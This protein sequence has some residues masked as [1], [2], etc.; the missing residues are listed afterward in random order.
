VRRRQSQTTTP[1]G[2][3]LNGTITVSWAR[4]PAPAS[5]DVLALYPAGAPAG[6]PPLAQRRT[7]GADT[8]STPFVVPGNLAAGTY[9]MR[10]LHVD[11]T[12]VGLSNPINLATCSGVC[13]TTDGA[14]VSWTGIASPTSTDFF[15]LYAVGAP[16]S[17][18]VP[19]SPRYVDC[20]ASAGTQ[21][22]PSGSCPLYWDGPLAPGSYEVRLFGSNNLDNDLG[23]SNAFV[24]GGANQTSPAVPPRADYRFQT[25]RASSVSGAPDVADVGSGGATTFGTEVVDGTSRAVLTFP[26]HTGLAV[27]TS[28]ILSAGTYS[29]V[30]LFRLQGIAGFNRLVDFKSGT[31]DHGLYVD[32]GKLSFYPV[33]ASTGSPLGANRYVQLVLTR[34]GT[35]KQVVGYVDGVQWLSFVDSADDG[36]IS[37]ANSLRFFKDDGAEDPS[38]AVARIRLFDYVLTPSVAVALDRLPPSGP[39][40]TWTPTPTPT[41]APPATPTPTPGAYPAAVLADHPAGYWRL[42]ETSGTT[43]ADSSGSA[44]NGTYQNGITLGQSGPMAGSGAAHLDGVDD[45]VSVPS[46][47]GGVLNPTAALSVESWVR[48]DAYTGNYPRLVSKPGV[49]ELVL[50]VYPGGE[51]RL[52]WD[53]Y[54]PTEVSTTTSYAQRLLLHTWY[55]VAATYDGATARLYVNGVERANRAVSGS[56]VQNGNALTLSRADRPLAGS[57]SEVAV[58]GTALTAAQVQA[59]YAAGLVPAPTP[60]PTAV[61]NGARAYVANNGGTT[62]S[63]LDLATGGSVGAA[64]VGSGPYGAAVNP[65]GSRAYVSNYTDSTLSVV[66]TASNTVLATVAVGSGPRGVAVSP[67]GSR[68]YVANFLGGTVSVVDTS[69][70]TVSRTITVGSGPL[71]LALRPDG[72]RLYV[73]DRNA[74]SLSVVDPSAGT[75]V[76][77]VAVPSAPRYVAVLPDGSHAYVTGSDTGQVAVLD[78]STNTLTTTI[79]IGAGAAP[80]GIAASPDGTK[81]YTANQGNSS[82]SVIA[83]ASNT[84]TGRIPI[85]TLPAT[86]A[87]SADGTRAYVTNNGENSVSLVDLVGGTELAVLPVGSLPQGIG[88]KPAGPP[89]PVPTPTATPTGSV[90]LSAGPANADPGGIVTASWGGIASPSSLDWLGLYVVGAPDSAELTWRY[91]SSTTPS[92]SIDFAL[93]DGLGA[94]TYELRLFANNSTQRLGASNPFT[95][96]PLTVTE[97]NALPGGVITAAW[98]GLA[99]PTTLDW[100]GLYTP[101]SDDA[102]R[103]TWRYTGSATA[104]GS[105]DFQLPSSLS[106]GSYELRLFGNDT[107]TR[108]GISNAFT[109]I[110]F[111]VSPTAANA[112]SVV[113]ASWAGIVDP[114]NTDW[115]GLYAPGAPDSAYQTWR[116]TS[117]LGSGSADFLLPST[118]PSGT[119]ELRLFAA[120]SYRRL[121]TSN[122]FTVTR[123]G[124]HPT[125]R[126]AWRAGAPRSLLGGPLPGEPGDEAGT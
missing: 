93:P 45:A 91:I 85:G 41:G 66:D 14:Q 96:L 114:T 58:Y 112:G 102:A 109:V 32:N 121:G 15:Q 60:T 40:P 54:T 2:P 31:T 21:G 122:V 18:P 87:L 3:A 119:Y 44:Q 63:A 8:G 107:Y 99:T 92:G 88:A 73:V 78:T 124:E 77:T 101:G 62:A 16:N 28:S 43:A 47:S 29:L 71:G 7:N 30:L 22:V 108:L 50:Y 95:V 52:E 51:G 67:D 116:Y 12:Q 42:N 84:V 57:L 103:L 79:P 118:L 126:L 64:T 100:L 83:T 76:A 25:S 86:L 39:P 97:G 46:A 24:V 53:V 113:S 36:V 115:L 27:D 90:S 123:V 75:V 105:V 125:D 59:H 89:A 106:P 61:T 10:V 34:D 20:Q 9:E 69:S 111:G 104:S 48:L 82:L 13:V 6:G 68:V 98:G 33:A 26:Q 38:G 1:G 4:L 17:S 120:G 81:V 35:T 110:T 74:N 70:N 19:G 80:W 65:A 23:T 11:G 117:G 72:T 56:L 37:A 49:Y 55:H 94:G 5:T